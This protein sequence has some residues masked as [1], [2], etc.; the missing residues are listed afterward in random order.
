MHDL[1]GPYSPTDGR[2]AIELKRSVLHV[3]NVGT[4]M[5]RRRDPKAVVFS[6]EQETGRGLA[7]ACRIVQHGSEYRIQLA[8]RRADYFENFG[9]RGFSL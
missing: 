6:A 3:G 8:G 1:P 5:Q 9:G 4:L 2:R 7:D